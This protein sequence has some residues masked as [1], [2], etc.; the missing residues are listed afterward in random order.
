M[1]NSTA[2]SSGTHV[3]PETATLENSRATASGVAVNS[4]QRLNNL[5][6]EETLQYQPLISF[7]EGKRPSVPCDKAISRC[8]D[9]VDTLLM[10]VW[11]EIRI[12]S[13]IGDREVVI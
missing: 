11:H 2:T 12:E 1:E 13:R 6:G 10:E 7:S 4:R 8:V 9:T 3:I 5:L